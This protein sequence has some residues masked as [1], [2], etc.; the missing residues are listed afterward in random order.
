[1]TNVVEE[2][3]GAAPGPLPLVRGVD[4][5]G[6]ET[7]WGADAVEEVS[8]GEWRA[9]RDKGLLGSLGLLVLL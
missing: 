6:D 2:E 8:C 4:V 3:K 7:P 1:M 9:A 5:V